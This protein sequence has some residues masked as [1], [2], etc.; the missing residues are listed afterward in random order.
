MVAY[1]QSLIQAS[2]EVNLS[3]NNLND[4]DIITYRQKQKSNEVSCELLI[5][6]L[7]KKYVFTSHILLVY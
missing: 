5:N 1:T 3:V 6:L 4:A 2:T 7:K